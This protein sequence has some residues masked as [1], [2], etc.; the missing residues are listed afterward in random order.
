[1]GW[2]SSVI[3]GV[4]AVSSSVAEGVKWTWNNV[5][6]SS[7]TLG[8]L[9]FV[10]K[11]SYHSLQYVMAGFTAIPDLYEKPNHSQ[12]ALGVGRIIYKDILPVVVVY[13]ANLITQDYFR[14]GHENDPWL[15]PYSALLVGLSL[16]D[17]C[18]KSYCV[19]KGIVATFHSTTLLSAGGMALNSHKKS[20]RKSP[21]CEVNRCNDK[22]FMS[23]SLREYVILNANNL[24]VELLGK[25]P[26]VG[27]PVSFI[28]KVIFQGRV[29]TRIITPDRCDRHKEMVLWSVLT[30]GLTQEGAQLAFDF[31]MART[32]GMPPFLFYKVLCNIILLF[33]INMA[34]HMEIPL[35]EAK[36]STWTDPF[37]AYEELCR[38]LADVVGA[39]LL[40]QIPK[41]F[42][43]QP[44][45][46]PFIPLIPTLQQATK[47]LNSDIQEPSKVPL[48]AWKKIVNYGC[49]LAIPT[50]FRNMHGFTHDPIISIYLPR[51]RRNVIDAIIAVEG[52]GKGA[53]AKTLAW[54]PNVVARAVRL[55]FGIPKKITL[56]VLM[57]TQEKDFWE[58]MQSLRLW[59]ERHGVDAPIPLAPRPDDT[60]LL[61]GSTKALQVPLPSGTATQTPP[62][63]P[64]SKVVPKTKDAAEDLN[65]VPRVTDT[66]PSFFGKPVTR[67]SA[68]EIPVR[69]RI[70]GGTVTSPSGPIP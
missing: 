27:K 7:T 42:K 1:M 22:R 49:D 14:A 64:E 21:L 45:D 12:I 33:N 10:A 29:V 5:P 52:I 39:G 25:V 3:N 47:L 54:S 57:L 46:P 2:F 63:N 41:Y 66:G 53:A 32:V 58:F 38:F 34:A 24:L 8:A 11:V 40:S 56:F 43:A 60:P 4:K 51:I 44:D 9:K 50:S 48:T 23:G 61:N 55:R 20:G 19:T 18:A 67:S 62:T 13:N 17:Y 69:R 37:N 59:F 68:A 30:L 35:A 15:T 65:R 36:G 16:V 26:Y 31:I 28:F 70:G 6:L